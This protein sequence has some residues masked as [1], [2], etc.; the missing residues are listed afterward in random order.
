[1]CECVNFKEWTKTTLLGFDSIGDK[2]EDPPSASPLS[3]RR[4][5]PLSSAVVNLPNT[6]NGAYY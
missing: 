2:T 3:V 1:M 4:P 6:D 5:L